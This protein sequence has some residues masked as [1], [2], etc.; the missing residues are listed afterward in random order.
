MLTQEQIIFY[1]EN[2]YLVV[3][4]VFSNEEAQTF[5]G[6]IRR[7]A[8]KDFA[9]IVNPD[10]FEA[11]YD[12]DERPKSDITLEEIKQTAEFAEY[13]MKSP[14]IVEM[15]EA[16]HEKE[17]VGLSSQFIFKE[18]HSPYCTQA[19][20]PHQDGWYPRA[21]SGDYITA[22]WFLRE[23]TVENGTIYVYP[24]SHTAG[25]LDA[26]PRKSFREDS[27]TSPGSEC[28]IPEPFAGNKVDVEIPAN[29]VVFLNGYCIH[30]SYPNNSNKS[31]PWHS[32]CYITKGADYLVG[33]NAKRKDIALR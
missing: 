5:L 7:H 25:L 29:S 10:R 31:R 12:Q 2:G 17:L 16:L 8:N 11:L 14:T 13:A 27:D 21:K 22:N 20:L 19:W 18:A 9:A 32:S 33:A 3:E 28:E 23:A 15:L 1:K 30:G 4:G 26:V 6:Y 24:G